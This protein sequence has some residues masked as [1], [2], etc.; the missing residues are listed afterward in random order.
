MTSLLAVVA[1][2]V[3]VIADDFR[4]VS[5][6]TV[7]MSIP[8][9][10][11]DPGSTSLE[12]T[13]EHWQAVCRMAKK[14]MRPQLS[15]E[16]VVHYIQAF[17]SYYGGCPFKVKDYV[18]V[19]VVVMARS[20]PMLGFRGGEQK[21]VSHKSSFKLPGKAYPVVDGLVTKG[22][23]T[24]PNCPK[25][26]NILDNYQN[27]MDIINAVSIQRVLKNQEHFQL[28][29]DLTFFVMLNVLLFNKL[30]DNITLSHMHQYAAINAKQLFGWEA[31][32]PLPHYKFV[33]NFRQVVKTDS[34]NYRYLLAAPVVQLV[35]LSQDNR[36]VNKQ[37]F[38]KVGCLKALDKNGLGA[39]KW[40]FKAFNTLG[41]KTIE[42][43]R[44]FCLSH[45]ETM[46]TM[47]FIANWLQNTHAPGWTYCR[48]FDISANF[49]LTYKFH[50]KVTQICVF[51]V[52]GDKGA[53]FL[54]SIPAL[55]GT[56]SE[57]K[58]AQQLA[59]RIVNVHN[60]RR[61]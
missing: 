41:L 44:E 15:T 6:Y 40:L 43:Q 2:S 23:Q 28:H 50:K 39:L 29:I 54:K 33:V 37:N 59:Q 38:L 12:W 13:E 14:M 7:I 4:T 46:P 31:G 45:Q 53:T 47:K 8:R 25:K 5:P 57:L 26:V 16:T 36:D 11:K 35:Q 61:L 42:E 1:F 27:L 17:W 21:E 48:L 34:T 18:A 60:N 51:I 19:F 3:L 58:I 52:Q 32:I 24:L 56:N 20:T 55:T 10:F 9:G 30:E 22:C 49:N